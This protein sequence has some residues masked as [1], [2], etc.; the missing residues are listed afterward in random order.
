VTASP[1]SPSPPDD[2]QASVFLRAAAIGDL[3]VLRAMLATTPTLVD[4][5]GPHPF[6]G[7]RPQALHVA[8]EN[9]RR[10]VFDLLLDSGADVDGINHAYDHWSPLML[11]AQRGHT[12]MR[13]GLLKRGARLGLAEALLVGD[14]ERVEERIGAGGLPAV[15]PNSG[16]WLAFAR[17]PHAIDRLVAAGA[18]TTTADRW[19]TTPLMAFCR[20][21]AG[22]LAL[23]RRLAEHGVRAGAVELA[24]V[25]DGDALARLV[26]EDPAV[27]HREDVLMAAVA[28][29]HHALASWLLDYGAP[30]TARTQDRS[31][32]T[33]LH[34]AAWQG[35]LR[36]VDLLVARGADP[37]ALD[38]EHRA[39]PR[40]WAETAITVSNNP[41]CAEVVAYLDRIATSE[42]RC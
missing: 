13:D 32:Q 30:V 20:L 28:G 39:T 8:I 11:A 31:R 7:G 41:R 36:M 1:A 24:R 16:S 22:G 14:D 25:G 18:S 6:W 27:A 38:E 34:E 17:T 29:R 42:K 15:V 2:V 12:D 33:A 4:A 23:V 3:A 35:D 21:E 10:D 37:R 5:V 40:D 26:D 9:G 19:G